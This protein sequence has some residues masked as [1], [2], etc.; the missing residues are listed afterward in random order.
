MRIL[1]T[2][3]LLVFFSQSAFAQQ[4]SDPAYANMQRAITG[5][6]QKVASER[7][8]STSDPRVYGTLYGMGTAATVAAA[9]AGTGLLVGTSPAWGTILAVAAISGAV[10]YGVSLGMDSLVKWIFGTPAATPITIVAPAAGTGQA[11]ITPATSAPPMATIV[12]GS[13]NQPYY[14]ITTSPP[15]YYLQAW[16]STTA[17]VNPG[18]GVY[19]LSQNYTLNGVT[20]YVWNDTTVRS[21]I[22][23]CPAGYSVS[24]SA[25]AQ[26]SGSGNMVTTALQTLTQAVAALTAAQQATQLND[27]T[28]A[29]MINYL[30]Q[31]AAAQ[32]GYVGL[33]YSP[34]GQPD[35]DA[36]LAS[37]PASYPPVAALAAPIPPGSNGL[38]PATSPTGPVV[39]DTTTVPP[40]AI[41]PA[42]SPQVNLG[43][44]PVVPFPTLSSPPDGP[45]IMAPIV[46]GLTPYMNFS[47]AMPAGVCPAPTFDF[48]PALNLTVP[49]TQICTIYSSISQEIFN[50]MTLAWSVLFLIVVLK[51]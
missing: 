48:R 49:S 34:I 39:P 12:A 38:I 40:D 4:L 22:L 47:V 42:S 5:I 27:Q 14:V 35:V 2:I 29:L 19:I 31:Q 18:P 44:D 1:T 37:N 21:S 36:F 9:T 28:L 11:T 51:A 16:F 43:A 50:V 25:C 45:T 20:Y 33:P 24:G 15:Y 32:P 13:I 26:N 41:N 8:F 3:F 7:G 17:Y 23:T 10:S 6:T 30:W 46:T